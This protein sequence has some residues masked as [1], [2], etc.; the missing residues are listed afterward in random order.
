MFKEFENND[1]VL[2]IEGFFERWRIVS[3]I[4]ASAYLGQRIIMCAIMR[5]VLQIS[6]TGLGSLVIKCEW[7]TWK[8]PIL[9]LFIISYSLLNKLSGYAHLITVFWRF[10]VYLIL[11]GLPSFYNSFLHFINEIFRWDFIDG[12]GSW[13]WNRL[14]NHFISFFVPWDSYVRWDLHKFDFE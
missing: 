14:I 12:E 10:L 1:G 4:H 6:H 5:E 7:V 13:G 9:A 2:L 8:W 11:V 3:R